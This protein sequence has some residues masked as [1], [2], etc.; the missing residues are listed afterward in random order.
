MHV[1]RLRR[2]E[3]G[4]SQPT[5]HVIRKL[6]SALQVGVDMLLFAKDR[7]GPGGGLRLQFDAISRFD[8]DEKQVIR[9][10]LEG[11]IL[12]HEARKWSPP[13]A[14]APHNAGRSNP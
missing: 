9:S 11:M 2:Y 3:A 13:A 14:E 7:R 6:S 5:L 4:A 8:G 10:P 12:K 1:V